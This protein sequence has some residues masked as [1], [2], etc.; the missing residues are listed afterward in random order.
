[1]SHEPPEYTSALLNHRFFRFLYNLFVD[2][3]TAVVLA[4]LSGLTVGYILNKVFVFTSSGNSMPREVG[5]FVLINLLALVQTWGLSVYLA[6]T[7]PGHLPVGAGNQQDVAKAIAHGAG[8][9]L[10]VFTSYIGHKYL[11]FRE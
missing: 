3:S 7:L 8:I 1:M 4:F 9:A 6:D 10:P 5:W 11:T 2:F